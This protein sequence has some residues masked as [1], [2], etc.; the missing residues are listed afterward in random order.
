MRT[1]QRFDISIRGITQLRVP[2]GAQFLQPIG[3]EGA[4]ALYGIAEY[5]AGAYE[6]RE[7]HAFY[8]GYDLPETG[9]HEQYCYLGTALLH[10]QAPVHIFERVKI[11]PAPENSGE[12]PPAK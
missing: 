4:I 7:I 6:D 12:S 3:N 8:S 10:T 2:T 5:D 11:E 9:E 1:I